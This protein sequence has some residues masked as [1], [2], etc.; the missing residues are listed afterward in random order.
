MRGF[1]A[2]IR[3]HALVSLSSALITISALML[4]HEIHESGDAAPD[5]LQVIQGLAQAVGF[6]G[7]GAIFVAR[8]SVKNLTTA[9]NIWLSAAQRHLLVFFQQND[10]S[11]FI[12]VHNVAMAVG[13]AANHSSHIRVN[14]RTAEW[15]AARW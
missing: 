10:F 9:A 1:A 3:T 2:G 13:F 6:I 4:Y 7:A 11:L 14:G 15:I 5:P 8:G 12:Y